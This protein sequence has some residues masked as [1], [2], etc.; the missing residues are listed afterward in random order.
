MVL[1]LAA[2]MFQVSSIVLGPVAVAVSVGAAASADRIAAVFVWCIRASTL[3]VHGG[4]PVVVGRAGVRP[5]SV[6]GSW[7]RRSCAG[8]A[9]SSQE[10]VSL[11]QRCTL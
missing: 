2:G 10:L 4:Y 3:A 11:F 1:P 8:V 5:R 7:G 9:I 6:Y